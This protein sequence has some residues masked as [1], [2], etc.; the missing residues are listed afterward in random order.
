ML[1]QT[2]GFSTPDAVEGVEQLRQVHRDE[3]GLGAVALAHVVGEDREGVVEA[4]AE[5]QVDDDVLQEDHRRRQ[6]AEHL[7]LGVDEQRGEPSTSLRASDR[8]AAH[9]RV[10]EALVGQEP[11]DGAEHAVLGHGVGVLVRVRHAREEG[12]V[13]VAL[14]GSARTWSPTSAI[15][16]CVVH[17][18]VWTPSS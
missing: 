2:I 4:Q 8:A 14:A 7:H 11:A 12:E 17:M 16:S 1:A 13:R 15:R 18:K 3:A 5:Q 10:E 6:P 9:R